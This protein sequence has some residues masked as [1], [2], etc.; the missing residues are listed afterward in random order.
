MS[1]LRLILEIAAAPATWTWA[2]GI[3]GLAP[4]VGAFFAISLRAERGSWGRLVGSLL[5]YGVAVRAW[6]AMLYVARDALAP[7]LP[8]RPLR[9]RRRRPAIP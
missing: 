5:V 6:V 4:L 3:T 2:A 9:R 8:L 7:R 1:L